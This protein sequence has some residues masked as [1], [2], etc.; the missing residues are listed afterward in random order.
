MAADETG[1]KFKNGIT[2]K[3]FSRFAPNLVYSIYASRERRQPSRKP[4][5]RNPRWPPA[6]ILNFTRTLIT[7]EP[8]VRLSPNLVWSFALTPPRHLKC[9]KCHFSKPNNEIA[10]FV[11]RRIAR[12]MPFSTMQFQ[13]VL[14]AVIIT[15]VPMRCS[16]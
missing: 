4:E 15:P 8:L 16:Q 9:Q 3:R 14:V 11:C 2:S 10:N 6:V 13:F 1:N 7:F 12:F 5:I